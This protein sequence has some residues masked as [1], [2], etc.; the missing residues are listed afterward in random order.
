MARAA[1][2]KDATMA[3]TMKQI[4][5][6]Q[7]VSIATVSRV[8][9]GSEDSVSDEVR[10]SIL[11]TAKRLGYEPRR[12]IGRTVAFLI[13]TEMFNLSSLFYTNIISAAEKEVAARRFFFQFSAISSSEIPLNRLNLKFNDLAGVV[14]VGTYDREFLIR[15]RT[16]H[17]P[18]ILV[19]YAVPTEDIDAI[20][21]DNVD[22]IMKAGKHLAEL[23]HRRVAY[24]SGTIDGLSAQER[25]HGF[26][27]ARAAYGFIE[28]PDLV[29]ECPESMSGGFEAMQRILGRRD[30]RRPTAVIAYNDMVAIGAMDAIKQQG[31]G[32]PGDMSIVGFDDLSLSAEV[33]P[34]L[35]T[36]QVPKELMGRLAVETLF[37][38]ISGRSNFTRKILLPTRLVVR[39]STAAPNIN[40][41]DR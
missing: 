17:I 9:S 4:A 41:I 26:N 7:G 10:R 11:E 8:L 22:G 27:L 31:L 23:G 38:A 16:Q 12:K 19:D 25:R 1:G 34:P 3:V 36:V 33:M 5:E 15:L 39:E 21:V 35:T 6:A 13:D 32:I 2:G 20:L 40:G 37:H 29:E 24:I 14:I 18:V 30:A 28:E